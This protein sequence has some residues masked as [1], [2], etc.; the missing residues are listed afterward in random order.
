MLSELKLSIRLLHPATFALVMATAIVA[1]ACSMLGWSALAQ[2]LGRFNVVAYLTLWILTLARAAWFPQEFFSD[3]SDH[4]RGVGFFTMVAGTCV[5]GSQCLLLWNQRNLAAFLLLLGFILWAALTYAI[6]TRLTVKEE[7]PSLEQGINGGWLLTVVAT[8]SVVVLTERLAGRF[9]AHEELVHFLALSLWLCGGM[10]YIWIISLIFYRYTFFRLQPSELMPP[11]WINMGAMAISTLAGAILIDGA[12]RSPLLAGLLP[13]LKGM[14][15]LFWATATWWIPML[16]I[17]GFW[18]HIIKR[19]RL[20]YDPLYWGAV[21]PLGMYT[22]CTWQLAK[23]LHLDFLL[24]IPRYFIYVAL[25]AWLLTFLG[26]LHRLT[27]LAWSI[28]RA[29][30]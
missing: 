29:H 13:F 7:K 15:L 17:L 6:L 10:L 24:P 16:L 11:Y 12:A 14:T 27:T 22:V 3:L 26:L 9:Q 19:F 18:R 21:F 30:R 2:L 25:A 20:A 4:N 23:A 1:I 8:Q 5:L 28:A